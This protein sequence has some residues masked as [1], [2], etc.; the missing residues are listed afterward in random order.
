MTTQINWDDGSG[1]KIYLTYSASEG[2]Q[3]IEVTS[4]AYNGYGSRTKTITFSISA[5]GSSIS[6]TLTVIQEGKTITIITRNDTAI[7]DNDTAVGYE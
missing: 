5:G 2:T 6:R 3:V 1:D 4:D 7:T